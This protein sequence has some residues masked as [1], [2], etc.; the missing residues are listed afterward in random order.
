[1][2]L[3]SPKSILILSGN[4]VM[5]IHLS[6]YNFLL[7]AP[8]TSDMSTLPGKTWPP[9]SSSSTMKLGR[10]WT[11]RFLQVWSL[12]QFYSVD[13]SQ[14][15]NGVKKCVF[16][17]RT[18]KVCVSFCWQ[19]PGTSAPSTPFLTV[20]LY[21]CS[22]GSNAWGKSRALEGRRVSSKSP[23]RAGNLDEGVAWRSGRE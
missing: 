17:K 5:Q 1:M 18:I 11:G 8:S 6:I 21:L 12:T 7:Q 15:A 20:S 13:F 10:A 9:K 19:C 14:S 3:H 4:S 2:G 22:C 16:N 23:S